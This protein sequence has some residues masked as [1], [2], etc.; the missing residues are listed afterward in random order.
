MATI[1]GPFIWEILPF[2][3]PVL[4]INFNDFSPVCLNKAAERFNLGYSF[5]KMA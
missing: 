3:G 4:A 1:L 5:H 2:L